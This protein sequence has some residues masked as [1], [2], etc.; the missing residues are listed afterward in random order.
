MEQEQA[1]LI[2]TSGNECGRGQDDE[3]ELQGWKGLQ[4]SSSPTNSMNEGYTPANMLE[5]QICI[6]A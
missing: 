1:G 3:K 6:D 4:G 5:K 2:G